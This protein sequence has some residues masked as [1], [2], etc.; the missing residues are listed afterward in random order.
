MIHLLYLIF[1]V[2]VDLTSTDDIFNHGRQKYEQIRSLSTSQ[3]APCWQNILTMLHEHCSIDQLD[4]YQGFIAYQ[5]TLCHLSTMNQDFDS[6][7]P[8]TE[9]NIH[10]CLEQLHQHMNAFIGDFSLVLFFLIIVTTMI[11]TFLLAYTEFYPFVQ[12]VCY[13]LREKSYQSE[14]ASRLNFFLNHSQETIEKLISS[15]H[16][17][18]RLTHQIHHQQSMQQTILDNAQ[19][20]KNLAR[21]NMDK[22][23]DILSRV[24]EAARH[25]YDLLKQVEGFCHRRSILYVITRLDLR[26]VTNDT[27]G[28]SYHLYLFLLVLRIIDVC[29]LSDYDS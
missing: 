28:C 4:R 15:I 25:E 18:Q 21:M 24:I 17:Q 13:V 7:S 9:D 12:S 14:L 6:L 3:T 22:T 16:I 27:N 8:C 19:K 10:Q 5:F 29:H 11:F 2:F 26:P 23:Q 20:L 1:I